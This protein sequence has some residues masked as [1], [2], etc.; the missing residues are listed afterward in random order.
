MAVRLTAGDGR[1]HS[2]A[3]HRGRR[4]SARL[5]IH[6]QRAQE[7]LGNRQARRAGCP[8]QLG[9]APVGESSSRS[10]NLLRRYSGEVWA[11]QTWLMVL[12][13]ELTPAPMQRR[14][15][16]STLCSTQCTSQ[17]AWYAVL[18]HSAPCRC[19]SARGA[20][21]LRQ[22]GRAAWQRRGAWTRPSSRAL[23]AAPWRALTGA[24][25]CSVPSVQR[26]DSTSQAAF[27][28]RAS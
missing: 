14:V 4:A 12:R 1:I 21:A 17:S 11:V 28:K 6:L 22:L 27:R 23:T 15:R 20:T 13:D 3:G 10:M 8:G 16:C 24:T 25:R 9:P 5:R 18:M 19:A 7:H 2:A 26:G